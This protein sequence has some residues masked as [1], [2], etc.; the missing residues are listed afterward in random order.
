MKQPT[1]TSA[2]TGAANYQTATDFPAHAAVL[3]PV[4]L[5]KAAQHKP[6]LGELKHKHHALSDVTPNRR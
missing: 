2:Q 6:A 3:D 4:Y 1:A 5:Y